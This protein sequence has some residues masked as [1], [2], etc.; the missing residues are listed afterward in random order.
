M[1]AAG[2]Y[3]QRRNV[4]ISRD[5]KSAKTLSEF[6]LQRGIASP[7]QSLKRMLN[8]KLTTSLVLRSTT[9]FNHCASNFESTETR[10]TR[11]ATPVQQDLKSLVEIEFIMSSCTTHLRMS[12]SNAK[13]CSRSL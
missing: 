6:S 2:Y 4:V 13:I 1:N 3:A 5:C 11:Q 9:S 7:G 8:G 10:S 12:G